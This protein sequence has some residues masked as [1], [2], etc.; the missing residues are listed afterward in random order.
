MDL[1]VFF[2]AFMLVCFGFSWPINL[3]KNIKLKSAKPM[4]LPFTLLIF[5]GY[6]A[7][8]TKLA[9]K[10]TATIYAQYIFYIYLL[11]FIFVA[12][13][14]FVYF[15]NRRLDKIAAANQVTEEVKEEAE[16]ND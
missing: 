1:V 4:N 8:I 7:G 3:I 9:I 5:V 16:Q 6:I 14:I 12:A 13:N 11:N 15:Y 10:Y 2:E